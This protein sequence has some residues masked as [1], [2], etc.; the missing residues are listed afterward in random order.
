MKFLL[1]FKYNPVRYLA[2]IFAS[3][4]A[5]F[6]TVNF[7]IDLYVLFTNP[8]DLSL[9]FSTL[10]NFFINIYVCYLLLRGNSQ[11]NGI[12]V[13]GFLLYVLLFVW[14]LFFLLVFNFPFIEAMVQLVRINF[15]DAL[16]VIPYFVFL[17]A[18]LVIG[19]IC[20]VNARRFLMR[21]MVKF[22]TVLLFSSLFLASII[23]YN[24]ISIGVFVLISGGDFGFYSEALFTGIA[25]I[26]MGISA[27]L[28]LYRCR[29]F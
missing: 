21:R 11:D 18:S 5:L 20:Y 26:F 14:D 9:M 27:F 8:I 4:A 15:L 23:I 1:R 24:G 28:S 22:S 13:Q 17:L 29:T 25:S 7:V 16:L 6:I 19:I 10:L 12:A 3:L 2:L